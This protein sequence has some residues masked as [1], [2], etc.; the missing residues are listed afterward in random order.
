M[1]LKKVFSA[2]GNQMLAD[3]DSIHSQ[4]RHLGE[5]GGER[6]QGLKSF[7]ET[8]LPS[9]YT[10]SNGEIVD[11]SGETSRQCDLVIYDK[12]NCPLLLAGKEY[13]VFPAEPVFAVVE[14][15]SVLTSEE[16][17][18][19]VEKIRAAKRLTRENGTVAGIIFAYKSGRKNDPMGQIASQLQ[20]LNSEVGP[21]LHTDLICVLDS[22]VIQLVNSEGLS[23]IS[24]NISER[25]MVVWHEL[26]IPVLLWFFIHLLGLLDGQATQSP[27]Y[28]HYANLFEIGIASIQSPS[29][30]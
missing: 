24:K 26:D 25:Q 4:I 21:R 22:G 3:F 13:R 12:S 10:V 30:S 29:A 9:R 15:K 18:D 11:D 8:Y 23:R 7:L 28:Q 6:E 20:K 1:D 17:R 16:L 27:N 5:R 2:I 14:V 19:A